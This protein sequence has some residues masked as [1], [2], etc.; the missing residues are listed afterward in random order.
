LELVVVL[1]LMSVLAFASQSSWLAVTTEFRSSTEATELVALSR[2]G[3]ARGFMNRH[4]V[5]DLDGSGS[6]AVDVFVSRFDEHGFDVTI[7]DAPGNARV[8]S[9]SGDFDWELVAAGDQ[10]VVVAEGT[11]V[12]SVVTAN[13]P[14]PFGFLADDGQVAT[15]ALLS[16]TAT[17]G[18]A[19]S[20]ATS[21]WP[22]ALAWLVLVAAGVA[23]RK[24]VVSR[25]TSYWVR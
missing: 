10:V 11:L 9:V 1:V 14:E 2:E 20:Q 21:W 12:S 13:S 23:G 4:T 5:A 15:A 22:V 16:G 3:V 17:T 6:G 8:A 19:G 25:R 7:D 18:Y 24:I